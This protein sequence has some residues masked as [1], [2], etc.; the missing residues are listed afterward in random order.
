MLAP[1]SGIIPIN[2]VLYEH[3][4]YVPMIGFSIVLLGLCKLLLSNPLKLFLRNNQAVL[5]CTTFTILA[6][7]TLR[8]NYFWSTPVRFYEYLIQHSESGRV[9]NN[10]AMA[11]A[12]AGQREKAL[13]AYE[14]SLEFGDYYPQIHHN[15]GNTHR[16]MGNLEKAEAE[17]KKAIELSPTFFHSYKALA[18]IY[19]RQ[20]K[21]QELLELAQKGQAVFINDPT[22][23]YFEILALSKLGK[24]PE[25]EKVLLEMKAKFPAEA[26]TITATEKLIK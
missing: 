20:N 18:E 5:S 21:Y 12:D 13:T 16:D 1:V 2:G 4:L 19:N 26:K 7:L 9:L 24:N 3:W 17:Y 25:A 11:Y 6:I 14:K 23:Y 10:L 15:M 8:Q 22:Y